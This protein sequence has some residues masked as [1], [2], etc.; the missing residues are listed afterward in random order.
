MPRFRSECL[1]SCTDVCKQKIEQLQT[2]CGGCQEPRFANFMT[3][4]G[5]KLVKC[6][7]GS[8]DGT[9]QGS[10]CRKLDTVLNTACCAGADGVMGNA[11]D[12][13]QIPWTTRVA[14]GCTQIVAAN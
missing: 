11:D 14:L 9:G 6:G 4:A 7:L 5:R 8:D 3:D 12:T 13:C 2:E 1:R 10:R